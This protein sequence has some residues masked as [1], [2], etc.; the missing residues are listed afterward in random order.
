MTKLKKYPKKNFTCDGC[1]TALKNAVLYSA[2]TTLKNLSK[3]K[4]YCGA[5]AE[6]LNAT[7]PSK[8]TL[9]YYQCLCDHSQQGFPA[10]ISQVCRDCKKDSAAIITQRTQQTKKLINAYQQLGVC[11][12]KLLYVKPTKQLAKKLTKKK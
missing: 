1:Q 6:Q 3:N 12:E 5:C 11:L 8:N 4:T 7:Q 9:A 2:A 10:K